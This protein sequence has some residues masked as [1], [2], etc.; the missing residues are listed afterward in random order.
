MFDVRCNKWTEWLRAFRLAARNL[1]TGEAHPEW[2]KRTHFVAGKVVRA[3]TLTHIRKQPTM[4]CID[5]IAISLSIWYLNLPFGLS[6]HME[7]TS[8]S[9]RLPD[10]MASS[11][12]HPLHH[13]YRFTRWNAHHIVYTPNEW[14]QF[15]APV[16]EKSAG[17]AE[18]NRCSHSITHSWLA[19][20]MKINTRTN[21]ERTNNTNK[22]RKS[23]TSM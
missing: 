6:S 1:V 3:H 2:V 4:L 20:K 15:E 7:S 21:S 23:G 9:L 11:D 19:S 10:T 5:K 18:G 8:I 16:G 22:H 17:K 14:T 13:F 12:G